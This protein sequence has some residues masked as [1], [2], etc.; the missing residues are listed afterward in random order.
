[1]PRLPR[2][3]A[4]HNLLVAVESPPRSLNSLSLARNS[5]TLPSTSYSSRAFANS[6]AL[7][8][9]P[10][11]PFFSCSGNARHPR[12][13]PPP[14]ILRPNQPSCKLSCCSLVLVDP[15]LPSNCNR[16]FVSNERR[17]RPRRGQHDSS[18]PTPPRL[19][20]QH[21]II[22]PE[23]YNHLVES[24]VPCIAVSTLAGV[25]PRRR[26]PCLRRSP[27]IRRVCFQLTA[28]TPSPCLTGSRAQVPC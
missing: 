3:S 16:S 14:S 21:H 18:I 25:C 19:P 7:N 5:I 15:L 24:L 11:P 12:G 10:S 23:L 6:R 8:H 1:M 13:Q 27:L 28:P 26:H 20:S 4:G 9:I 22:T 2:A 17:L